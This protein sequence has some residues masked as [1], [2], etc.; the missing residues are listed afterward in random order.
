M[1]T[2]FYLN[3]LGIIN[4]LG[5]DKH[6]VCAR[7]LSGESG[8]KQR[9]D[10]ISGRETWLGSIT[11][12][13]PMIPSHFEHFACRNNQILLHACLQIMPTIDAM[14][15]RY[16]RERI[17]IVLGTSTSGIDNGESAYKAKR[18]DDEFP[19]TFDYQQQEIGGMSDFLKAYLGL[20]GIAY[21]LSTA[22]SS[23]GKAFACAQRLLENN[24]CDAV[25]VGGCDSLCELTYNGF[26]CLESV[27][28]LPCRPFNI[29]RDGISIGEGA[30][31]F[32]LSQVPS[33]IKLMGVGESSDGYHITAPHPDGEGAQAVMRSALKHA[34]ISPAQVGYVNLHGTATPKN[35]EMEAYAITQVFDYPVPCSS[36]KA[37]TGHTLGAAAATELGLCWLMLH[38]R[39]NPQQWL[40]CQYPRNDQDLLLDNINLIQ[41][42]IQ[43]QNPIMMS[44]SFAF[45]GSNVSIVIGA[46]QR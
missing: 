8:L 18:T 27:S 23:S 44:N 28:P 36:T 38:S 15:A 39:F 2:A 3:D 33:E 17:A 21:T 19:T 34:S 26:D 11:T 40:A 16:G 41:M 22:C 43:W 37:L 46:V 24:L 6:Q 9:V 35:D 20:E 25:I 12:A 10:L 45:G 13:L 4:A 32:V 5:D 31:L 1:T 14:I 29:D 7:L 42:P 30:A